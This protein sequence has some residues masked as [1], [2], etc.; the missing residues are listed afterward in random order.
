MNKRIVATAVLALLVG[1]GIGYWVSPGKQD[2]AQK[3]ATKERK[4]LFYRNPMNPEMTSPVPA[5]DDMGMAYIPVYADGHQAGA[6]A[7]EVRIDPT[8]VQDSGVRTTTARRAALSRNIRTI[9]RVT[10]DEERVVRLHPKYSGWVEKLYVDKTGEP[11]RK[12]SALLSVYSPQVVSTQEEYLLA[13]NNAAQLKNSPFAEVR[14]S[15]ESLL[16]STRERLRLFDVPE[17]QIDRLGTERKVMKGALIDSPFSGIVM[18][19]GA[20]EGDRITPETELYM[21]VDLSRI[22]VLAD[23]YESDMPWVRVG[24]MANMQVSDIPGRV[25]SGKV[26]YIY[27]YLDAKTR[28]VKVR[29]E[30][31]NP[32]LALKPDMYANVDVQTDRQVDAIVVP[33]EAILR[34]GTRNLVFVQRAPGKFEPRKV[35]LGVS[36]NGETQITDGLKAGEIVVTSGQFLLDSESRLREATAR[37][38]EPANAGATRG[39]KPASPGMMQHSKPGNTGDRP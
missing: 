8:V 4:P 37:M 36:S 33:S 13:L 22:W 30:L 17:H 24:D 6:P 35:T 32:E 18:N 3:I 29:I 28:T 38:L 5:K 2:A 34:T 20:R 9:G 15:A 27:P 12:G 31:D 10:Y 11:V 26:S 16:H 1:G 19:I 23:L 14:Q 25:F 21:I 39:T 7:G